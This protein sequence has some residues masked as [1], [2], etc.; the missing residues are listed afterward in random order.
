M[1][2]IDDRTAR[3]DGRGQELEAEVMLLLDEMA[4]FGHFDRLRKVLEYGLQLADLERAGELTP[5][6]FQ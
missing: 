1:A 5:E 2:E 4:K 3:G 6:M